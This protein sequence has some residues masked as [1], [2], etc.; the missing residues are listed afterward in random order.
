ME[1][2]NTPES[3][4]MQMQNAWD[5]QK[6]EYS[7]R[8]IQYP[9]STVAE[10]EDQRRTGRKKAGQNPIELA[11]EIDLDTPPPA[12]TAKS[13]HR[14]PRS[15]VINNHRGRY[16]FLLKHLLFPAKCNTFLSFA[17][18]PSMY[19]FCSRFPCVS[20]SAIRCPVLPIT[21]PI[22]IIHQNFARCRHN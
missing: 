8:I 2:R 14:D 16:L 12:P 7:G 22:I 21:L 20:S 11:H 18:N 3:D 9:M 19:S 6:R 17:P 5:D 13:L 1:G 4:C 15:P 10:G